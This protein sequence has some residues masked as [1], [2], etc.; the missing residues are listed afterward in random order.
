MDKKLSEY[1]TI[2]CTECGAKISNKAKACPKCGAGTTATGGQSGSH[3]CVR[4][5]NRCIESR[6][7]CVRGERES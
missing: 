3:R 6:K 5:E 4:H 2:F 7:T 1:K